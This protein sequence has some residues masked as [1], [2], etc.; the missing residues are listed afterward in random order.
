VCFVQLKMI[1]SY[2]V[3]QATVYDL[4]RENKYSG[5]RFMLL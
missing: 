5:H 1:F 3:N 4:R 2:N